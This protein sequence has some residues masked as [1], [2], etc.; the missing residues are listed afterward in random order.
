MVSSALNSATSDAAS[1][2]TGS[3]LDIAKMLPTLPLELQHAVILESFDPNPSF[4]HLDE[5]YEVLARLSLV[6]RAWRALIEPL[7]TVRV[8]HIPWLGCTF[9]AMAAT[10]DDIGFEDDEAEPP[11]PARVEE[12]DQY[13]LDEI[14]RRCPRTEQLWIAG[15][16]HILTSHLKHGTNLRS[17]HILRCSLCDCDTLE[18]EPPT[19]TALTR[20]E[21]YAKMMSDS[22]FDN[23]FASTVFPSLRQFSYACPAED[24]PTR[25]PFSNFRS[26]STITDIPAALEH[27]PLLFLDLY[28]VPLQLA[29]PS[30][31][32]TLL[33]LRLND[34]S[35]IRSSV[36]WL[37]LDHSTSDA[38][39]ARLP[40]LRELWLPRSYSEWRD[41]PKESVRSMVESW[42]RK[43]EGRGVAVIFEEDG[44]GDEA[45]RGREPEE[46]R[47]TEAAAFDFP[48]AVLARKAERWA[49]E[50]D[51]ARG[52]AV[53]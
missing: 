44:D 15:V 43:W 12:A 17:L 27:A 18:Y 40:R 16:R 36:P 37:L 26:V 7:L 11:S 2:K 24:F 23:F 47:L 6:S 14:L 35:P 4:S 25:L 10:D 1:A 3:S 38:L 20:L 32:R 41:D 22:V 5:R 13:R 52:A 28:Q 45:N 51:E 33:I 39:A 19:F 42:V 53:Q 30:L 34:F 8:G 46:Q 31:P 50:E 9:S 48:F 49:A 29:L 21:I